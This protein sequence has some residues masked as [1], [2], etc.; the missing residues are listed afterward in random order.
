[1]EEKANKKLLPCEACLFALLLKAENQ[2]VYVVTG[3]PGKI[4]QGVC[5]NCGVDV[6]LC[7][8]LQDPVVY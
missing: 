1:M 2:K 3:C 5:N 7:R 4:C 6:R 8:G